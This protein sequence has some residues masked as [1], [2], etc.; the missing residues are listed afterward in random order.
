MNITALFIAL[1]GAIVL[2]FFLMRRLRTKPWIE[3]GLID[4]PDGAVGIPAERIGL[5]IF[6][7]VVTS[8]FS[9]LTIMY[10]E[11]SGSVDWR[12]LPDPQLLWINT[13]FLLLGSVAIQR[14]RS[15]ANHD[16]LAGVKVN[17]TAGGVFTIVFVFGQLLAWDQ[18]TSSGYFLA[19]NPADTFFYLLTGL[20]GLHLFGGLWVWARTTNRVWRKLS[21]LNVTQIAEVRLSIQLCSVYWHFLLI[22]WLMLFYLL[23]ST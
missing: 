6:L 15:A 2:W 20:H 23:S 19:T 13:I 5:W 3:K 22:L 18:L 16:N 4:V 7:A 1:G 12:P 9:L 11:R 10:T 8:F 14:A 17:L 21:F